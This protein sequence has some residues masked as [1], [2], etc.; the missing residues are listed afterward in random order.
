MPSCLPSSSLWRKLLG[1]L[2][3]PLWQLLVGRRQVRIHLLV[4]PAPRALPVPEKLHAYGQDYSEFKE[5]EACQALDT[6]VTSLWDPRR[7]KEPNGSHSGD[8]RSDRRPGVLQES[9]GGSGRAAG[10]KA[11]DSALF[12]ARIGS[13]DSAP[14]VPS[15][16]GTSSPGCRRERARQDAR[17]THAGR[18]PAVC[19]PSAGQAPPRAAPAPA[20]G[21]RR[22]RLREIA[23]GLCPALGNRRRSLSRESTRKW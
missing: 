5:E 13:G 11:R 12:P 4:S 23:G 10:L 6:S 14:T 19:R 20:P 1:L 18:P 9:A 2:L 16:G 15:P 3:R 8:V 21:N 7:K 17:V 22:H